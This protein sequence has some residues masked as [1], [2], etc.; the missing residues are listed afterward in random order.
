MHNPRRLGLEV[1]LDQQHH[2]SVALGD[3]GLLE[4][5]PALE[6]A[7]APLQGVVQLVVGCAGVAAKLAEG[8][9]GA[10]QDFTGRTD[11]PGNGVVNG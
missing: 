8:G 2:P 5:A 4:H 11:G 1:G 7:Q 6:A 10:V 3:D 9:A